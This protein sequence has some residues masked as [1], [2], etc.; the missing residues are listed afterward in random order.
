MRKV[1]L[2]SLLFLIIDQI[3]KN[4]L[5]FTLSFD[6][7]YVIIHNFFNITLVKN[8]GA[9]FSI[10]S[11]STF[12]LS[13]IGIL[14]MV[15]LYVFFIKDKY[16]TNFES[17]LYGALAGGILGNLLDRILRGY[18]IDYLDFNIFGYN[19]PVFNLADICI[20]ISIIILVILVLKGDKHENS[21]E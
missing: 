2:I 9:A 16:L 13:V 11:S 5:V 8:T 21:S 14:A 15:I 17:I 3:I 12:L 19:F 4:I 7:P 10:L 20:T 1:F 18:V 6:T